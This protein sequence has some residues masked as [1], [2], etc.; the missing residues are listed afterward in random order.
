MQHEILKNLNAK[1]LLLHIFSSKSSYLFELQL[2][3]FAFLFLNAW[4]T[5]TLGVKG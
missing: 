3:I 2:G 1:E 4:T 5:I